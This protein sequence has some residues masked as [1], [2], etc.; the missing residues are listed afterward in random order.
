MNNWKYRKKGERIVIECDRKYKATL[1]IDAEQTFNALI[2][3]RQQENTPIAS[4]SSKED[5]KKPAQKFAQELLNETPEKD[6]I[7]EFQAQANKLMSNILRKVE[8][9]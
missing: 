4:T 7:K 3:L 5:N 6:A 9:D 2:R 1:P 8:N